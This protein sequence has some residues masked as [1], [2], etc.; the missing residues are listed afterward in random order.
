[1]NTKQWYGM[2]VEQK[3]KMMAWND[4]DED[5]RRVYLA[6]AEKQFHKDQASLAKE[7]LEGIKGAIDTSHLYIK[8]QPK[9]PKKKPKK[10]VK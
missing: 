8:P 3:A 10:K 2:I 1:M 5:A 6:E 7:L 9:T 4:L